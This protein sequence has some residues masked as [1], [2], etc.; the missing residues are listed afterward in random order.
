M[1]DYAV[2][3]GDIIKSSQLPDGGLDLIFNNLHLAADV[4]EKWQGAP[5]YLTRNRG[6]GWQMVADPRFALRATF[7]ARAAVR[8]TDRRYDTRIA[9]AVDTGTLA[10]S[11]LSTASGPAFIKSGQALEAMPK[12][13][14]FSVVPEGGTHSLILRLAEEIIARWTHTQAALALR[15]L[16]PNRPTQAE[17]ALQLGITQQSVQQSLDASGVD[18]LIDICEALDAS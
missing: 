16:A 11:D 7:A 2:L 13:R 5:A 9:L 18:A 10:G 1:A 8:M 4:I 3:T 6:D 15:A 12:K 17:L 14:T